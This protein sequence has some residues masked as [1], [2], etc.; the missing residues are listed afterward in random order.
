MNTP[1]FLHGKAIGETALFPVA[2]RIDPETR[3]ILCV[4]CD[5]PI[6]ADDLGGVGK[7][8]GGGE[9]WFHSALPCMLS[10]SDHLITNHANELRGIAKGK[11]HSKPREDY[12]GKRSRQIPF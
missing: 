6:L 9:A 11:T 5:Q 3:R 8:E 1:D 10:A 2:S 12:H 4:G 7:A